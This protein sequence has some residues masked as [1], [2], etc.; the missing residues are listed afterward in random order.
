MSEGKTDLTPSSAYRDH[1]ITQF[2][3][4]IFAPSNES[5]TYPCVRLFDLSSRA[6]ARLT[7][8]TLLHALGKIRAVHGD[9]SVMANAL[10]RI[11]A[12]QAEFGAF[13][14]LV[15]LRREGGGGHGNACWNVLTQGLSELENHLHG[16]QVIL[17]PV[18]TVSQL[19]LYH[20]R[21]CV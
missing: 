4:E 13:T 15:T 12:L 19:G 18:K 11:S 7:P 17:F 21:H 8:G 9:L 14:S 3:V 1:N 2:Q 16:E 20:T 10:R 6:S 5:F